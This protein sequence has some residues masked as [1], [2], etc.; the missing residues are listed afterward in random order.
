[1]IHPIHIY[2]KYCGDD[3]LIDCND[4]LISNGK[5]Y[6]NKIY[7]DTHHWVPREFDNYFGRYPTIIIRSVIFFYRVYSI[8]GTNLHVLRIV[9]SVN[10]SLI[11]FNKTCGLE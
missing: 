11:L 3:L 6:V 8:F 2:V 5:Y 9:V 10:G 7:Y 4:M 1:M